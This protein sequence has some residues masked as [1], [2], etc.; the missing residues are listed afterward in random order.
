[1]CIV[2]FFLSQLFRSIK[3]QQGNLDLR[4]P[5]SG[6]KPCMPRGAPHSPF[7]PLGH[8]LYLENWK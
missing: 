1:M 7:V 2:Q 5:D 3:E 8:L 6:E 4:G